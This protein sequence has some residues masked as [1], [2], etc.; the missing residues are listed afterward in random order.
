MKCKIQLVVVSDD[1]QRETVTEIAVLEKNDQR[2]EHLGLMLAESK[3]ILKGLQKQ[4]VQ[5]QVGSFLDRRRGCRDCG[6]PRRN[7]GSQPIPF[8]TL[9]GNIALDSPRLRHCRCQPRDPDL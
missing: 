9:F 5:E 6:A 3:A 7:K 2:V 1:G 4:I 8:R